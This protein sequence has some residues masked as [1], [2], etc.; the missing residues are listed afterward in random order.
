MQVLYQSVIYVFV[1]LFLL[2]LIMDDTI[3]IQALSLHFSLY[4][5]DRGKRTRV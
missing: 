2:S 1:Q 4:V 5:H 3:Y